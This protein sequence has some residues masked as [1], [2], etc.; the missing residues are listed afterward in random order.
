VVSS[1]SL[2]DLAGH[3]KPVRDVI[4]RQMKARNWLNTQAPGD[5]AFL[6]TI[7]SGCG[8]LVLFGAVVA[9]VGEQWLPVIGIFPL[10]AACVIA[11]GLAASYS[12]LSSE[13][14]RAALPWRA[15][16]EGLQK[17]PV[18]DLNKSLADIVA[19]NLGSKWSK[20][21]KEVDTTTIRAFAHAG[22]DASAF[23]YWAGFNATVS[24]A[25]GS[26]TV[27]SGGAGGGGGAA[28]ST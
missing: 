15:Y 16:R 26:S 8:V 17:T 19:L 20:R 3:W 4:D 9:A 12:G 11:V 28:G 13:G 23:P 18:V 2:K 21:M 7:A 5:G 27:S 1:K 25:S 6:I 24:S 22:T 10:A 14:Q